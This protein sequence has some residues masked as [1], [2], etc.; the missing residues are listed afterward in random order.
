MFILG[1]PFN[2]SFNTFNHLFQLI[3]TNESNLSPNFKTD[4][5]LSLIEQEIPKFNDE[6]GVEE[7]Y[8][9]GMRKKFVGII[10][11]LMLPV[12]IGGLSI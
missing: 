6:N 11:N 1:K 2:C 4:Y 8:E 10:W 12:E 3:R 5:I 9:I 7:P